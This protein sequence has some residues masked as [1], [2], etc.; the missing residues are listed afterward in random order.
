MKNE[1]VMEMDARMM[2]G[3]GH[4]DGYEDGGQG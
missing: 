2:R 3:G 4:N 1:M